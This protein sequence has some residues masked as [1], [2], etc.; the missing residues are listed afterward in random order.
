MEGMPDET[1]YY[2]Y[3]HVNTDSFKIYLEIIL[4]PNWELIKYG[5]N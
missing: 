4:W 3:L 2:H 1:F 5:I